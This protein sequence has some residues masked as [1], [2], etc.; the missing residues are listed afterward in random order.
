M[1]AT[2]IGQPRTPDQIAKNR[3]WFVLG[4]I[5]WGSISIPHLKYVRREWGRKDASIIKAIKGDPNSFVMIQVKNTRIR[6]H[7]LWA[8][9][10]IDN[11]R[12]Y[13]V[14]DPLYGDKCDVISRYGNSITGAAYF[15]KF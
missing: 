3:F 6:E 11:G 14:A 7:W 2:Y 4:K 10:V 12:S 8:I 13:L 1:M 5:L 15:E 9:G